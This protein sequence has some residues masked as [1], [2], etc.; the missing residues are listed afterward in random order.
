V[1][2]PRLLHDPPALADFYQAAIESLG[3]LCERSWHDAVQVVA[4]GHAARLWNED[5]SLHEV[6]LRFVPPDCSGPRAAASEVFPGCPLTFRLTEAL[7]PD[8]PPVDRVV[9]SV[10]EAGRPPSPQI[11][12]KLWRLQWPGDGLWHLDAPFRAAH[13]VSLVVLVR[14]EIQAIDQHWSQHRVAVALDDG[15]RD[16]ALAQNLEFAEIDRSPDPDL[17]WPVPDPARWRDLL[18]QALPHELAGELAGVRLRQQRYLERELGRVDAYFE[19]Y[20]QE[21]ES[22]AA[23]TEGARLKLQER[24]EAARAEHARRRA[25]QVQRHEVRVLPRIDALLLV[26]EPAWDTTITAGPRGAV[27]TTPARLVPRSRRWHGLGGRLD[28]A[29]GAR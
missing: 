6:E 15:Q 4:E 27:R 29:D 12:E 25:D 2:I 7:L 14:A 16:D 26:A 18:H 17:T 19:N 24:V 3:G 5:G 11:A 1:K 28:P 23:R 10:R 9:L 8:P 21:L 13:H 20:L 22:R